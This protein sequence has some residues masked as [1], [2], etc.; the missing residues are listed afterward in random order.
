MTPMTGKASDGI[1]AGES[2]IKTTDFQN[3]PYGGSASDA[4]LFS[5]LA[6]AF[7]KN[8]GVSLL[9]ISD[10]IRLNPTDGILRGFGRGRDADSGL[11]NT[12]SGVV[13]QNSFGTSARI[14]RLLQC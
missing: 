10:R 3:G 13:R 4:G 1:V 9:W 2:V 11:F 5:Y 12:E 14:E 7:P 8:P 6:M